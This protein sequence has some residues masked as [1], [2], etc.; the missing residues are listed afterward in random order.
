MSDITIEKNGQVLA[1]SGN[2]EA[3]EILG[4]PSWEGIY[5]IKC[6]FFNRVRMS[7]PVLFE[8]LA[9][10]GLGCRH[11]PWRRRDTRHLVD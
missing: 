3:L 2:C 4:E 6:Y 7:P 8:H 10:I 9:G 1:T 11:S 5:L